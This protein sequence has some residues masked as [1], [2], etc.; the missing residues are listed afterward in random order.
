[1]SASEMNGNPIVLEGM[2]TPE[3]SLQLTGKVPLPAG[4]VQVTLEPLRA[5][6]VAP[7][8]ASAPTIEQQVAAI[9]A[10]LPAE[11]WSKLP[12]DLTDHLDQYIYG[13]P[14]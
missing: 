11:E 4:K 1:M 14:E 8:N 5:E 2:V 7:Q 9:W 6:V 3:G 12:A 13:A 10:D